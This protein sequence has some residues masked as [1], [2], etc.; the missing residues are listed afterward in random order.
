VASGTLL[1]L[2]CG[3]GRHFSELAGPGFSLIGGDLSKP[4]LEQAHRESEEARLVCFE[5]ERLPFASDSLDGIFSG[6]FFHHIPTVALLDQ[7]LA[8]M[9]RVSTLAVAITYK[10]RYSAEH[11]ELLLKYAAQRVKPKRY[12]H[13]IEDFRPIAEKHGWRVTKTYNPGN[14]L[15]ANRGV[16]FEPK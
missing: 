12:F 1:D 15:S 4:M 7:I 8:E 3:N 2:A 11:L 5:A 14:A 9:F 16:L 6:R 10:A 13:S